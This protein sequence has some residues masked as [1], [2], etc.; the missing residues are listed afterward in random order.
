MLKIKDNVD[1]KE[2]EDKYNLDYNSD[3]DYE[4]G[5]SHESLDKDGVFIDLWDRK[6]TGIDATSLELLYD[7]I[8]ADLVEK[9]DE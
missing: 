3:S 5:W 1:L 6:I 4:G 8:K 2:L 7:L 9:V